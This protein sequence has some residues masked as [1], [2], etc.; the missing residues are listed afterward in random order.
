MSKQIENYINAELNDNDRHIALQFVSF[1]RDLNLEFEKDENYW[2]NKIYFY[3]KNKDDYI[4]YIAISDPDEPNNK[5]TVWLED[6]EWYKKPLDDKTLEQ[7]GFDSIDFCGHCGSCDGGTRKVI[8]GKEFDNVCCTIFRFDN[9]SE[10]FLPIVC[11]MV[12]L[13]NKEILES[14]IGR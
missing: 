5:W 12:E 6:G 2:K 11:K 1:L 10:R 13:R 14:K 8:F 9:L 4:C 3:V 7:I